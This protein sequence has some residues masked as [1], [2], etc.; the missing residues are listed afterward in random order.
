MNIF[1][2]VQKCFG[3]Q[4]NKYLFCTI[5]KKTLK[6]FGARLAHSVT[7]AREI[8]LKHFSSHGFLKGPINSF[9]SCILAPLSCYHKG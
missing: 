9:C 3:C 8:Y 5:K 7:A 1:L 6:F 2:D 4:K